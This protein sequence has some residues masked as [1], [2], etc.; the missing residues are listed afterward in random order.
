MNKS[1]ITG[2][3]GKGGS[4]KT[5]LMTALLQTPQKFKKVFHK[6]YVF[7][8]SSSRASLKNNIFGTLPENQ[9]FEGVNFE[10]LKEVYQNLLENS[11]NDKLS[12]LIFD[13]VQS[14][15][16]IKE[17]EQNLLHI[18]NN[19]RHLRTSIFILAQNYTKIPI[20]IRKVFTDLFLFNISKMEY[21][22]IQE[23]LINLSKTEFKEVLKLY[24]KEKK[25]E[26]HSFLYIHDYDTIFINWNELIFDDDED[27]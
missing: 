27:I 17:V 12:L 18:I 6:I 25:V 5:S 2:M 22:K 23:E 20:N 9:L 11:E 1:F 8:P 4:G 21:E 26:P 14:Y 24:K 13:D 16:K 15:L 10:N 3:I 7:M 19:R